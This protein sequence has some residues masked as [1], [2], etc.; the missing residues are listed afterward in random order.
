VHG[1]PR[2]QRPGKKNEQTGSWEDGDVLFIRG[3]AFKEHAENIAESLSISSEVL[4]TGR[5]KTD[6]WQGKIS[7]EKRSSMVLDRSV[8]ALVNGESRQG[9]SSTGQRIGPR[10]VVE[11]A[12]RRVRGSPALL[13]RLPSPTPDAGSQPANRCRVTVALTG[14]LGWRVDDD[15]LKLSRA[16]EEIRAELGEGLAEFADAGRGELAAVLVLEQLEH[17]LADPARFLKL[18]MTRGPL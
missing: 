16:G 9:R 10:L 7:G 14:C 13:I 1:Q 4:I 11:C 2:V 17:D 15:A 18:A 5:L 6:Q 12:G 3:T 8:S